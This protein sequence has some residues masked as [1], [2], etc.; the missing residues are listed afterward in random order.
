MSMKIDFYSTKRSGNVS[1]PRNKVCGYRIKNPIMKKGFSDGMNAPRDNGV[2]EQ[3]LSRFATEAERQNA[4][5]NCNGN[6]NWLNSRQVKFN[7]PESAD[8]QFSINRPS[9]K[10]GTTDNSLAD[11]K[12]PK[13]IREGLGNRTIIR[14]NF[15]APDIR[16]RVLKDFEKLQSLSLEEAG[17][18]DTVS[19][20]KLGYYTTIKVPDPTDFTWLREKARLETE[21]TQRFTNAG[22][23]ADEIS[24]MV[25]RELEVNPPL[26]RGQRTITRKSN[27]IANE[28]RLD[29]TTKIAEII[30]EV[31]AGRAENQ[32]GRQA[33][34][35]QLVLILA[36][37]NAIAEL[38][39]TQL[40]GLGNSLARMGI[41]TTHKA[42]GLIPRY[43]DN[44]YYL[45]NSG[46]INLLLF[47]RVRESN[48]NDSYNYEKI[49]KNFSSHPFDGLPAI[50]LTSMVASLRRIGENG[51]PKKENILD[52]ES[53]GV[54]SIN[55]VR[56]LG[57][58][59]N[60]DDYS[61]LRELQ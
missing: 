10:E 53:C 60:S 2:V 1:I 25:A 61:I 21:L 27:D 33:I 30:Q 17:Y 36:D 12:L 31:Q 52:L 32:A 54:M 5:S 35:A 6:T 4:G 50:K 28:G 11:P 56:A 22:F 34:T 57:Q 19:S 38:T 55:Q 7:T 13:N 37:T 15:L 59:M 44:A 9:F 24:A 41:P 48:N 29:T 23:P 26:G 46:L 16:N 20:N 47:S 3:R 39:R 42:L 14:N 43:V 40:Q 49:V 45:D 51:R 58:D 8:Q 18:P